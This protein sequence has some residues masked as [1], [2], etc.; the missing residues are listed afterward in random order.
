MGICRK[1]LI[2]VDYSEFNKNYTERDIKAR[3]KCMTIE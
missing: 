3:Q 2:A 1:D